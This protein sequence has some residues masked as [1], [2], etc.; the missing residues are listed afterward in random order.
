MGKQ[1][2]KKITKKK[3]KTLRQSS[4]VSNPDIT[5]GSFQEEELLHL[6]QAPENSDLLD[7]TKEFY[8]LLEAAN[9]H[10]KTVSRSKKEE[11]LEILS[12][13]LVGD[14]TCVAFAFDETHML[15]AS[16]RNNH[17]D[18]QVSVEPDFLI[19]PGSSYRDGFFIRPQ[20][21]VCIVKESKIHKFEQ[22]GEIVEF[23]YELGSD[24][25]VPTKDSL[26]F[27]P[28]KDLILKWGELG[29]NPIFSDMAYTFT[30]AK[31]PE[32]TSSFFQSICLSQKKPSNPLDFEAR[33]KIGIRS[34]LPKT[35]I[36]PF[37][38]RIDIVLQ[39]LAF[40]SHLTLP[41]NEH[42]ALGGK[43]SLKDQKVRLLQ[44][45]FVW[46]A[47]KWFG[48][49]K[50]LRDYTDAQ[51]DKFKEIVDNFI[52]VIYEKF[53]SYPDDLDMEDRLKRVKEEIRTGKI[54]PPQIFGSQIK[55]FLKDFHR[56]LKDIEKVE[57]F[58][59]DDTKRNGSLS[60]FLASKV[61]P[62]LPSPA[63]VLD[64][65]EDNVHAEM[66]VILH[67]ILN[68][69]E[70]EHIAISKLCCAHCTLVM[71]QLGI[72]SVCGSHA[73]AYPNWKLSDVFIK[74]KKLLKKILGKNLYGKYILLIK[75]MMTL[76]GEKYSKGYLA[77]LIIQS[78]AALSE[79]SLKDLNISN[80]KLW[81]EGESE[82]PDPLDEKS[83]AIQRLEDQSDLQKME[84]DYQE[85]LKKQ[86]ALIKKLNLSLTD[87]EILHK[88][89][90]L[91]ADES[92]LLEKQE[93]YQLTLKLFSLHQALVAQAR[94]VAQE[95]GRDV[96]QS[97][98]WYAMI[99]NQ[100][101]TFAEDV[102]TGDGW[103][104]LNAAGIENPVSSLN[105][106]RAALNDH[107]VR[108]YLMRSI[109][110]NI[111]AVSLGENF[112]IT[113]FDNDN[114][115]IFSTIWDLYFNLQTV[116]SNSA[117][118]RD[119]YDKFIGYISRDDVLN[120][121]LDYLIS[122]RY[123][124]QNIAAVCLKLQGKKLV[125]FHNYLGSGKLTSNAA[126]HFDLNDP[127]TVCI[128][129]HPGATQSSAHYNLLKYSP[130]PVHDQLSR[131]Q[132]EIH[133][134]AAASDIPWDITELG[135]NRLEATAYGRHIAASTNP[136]SVE[137]LDEANDTQRNR[138]DQHDT[139]SST[140]RI[141]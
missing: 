141:L 62:Y 19:M 14:E 95:F 90:K 81:S 72:T 7:F 96:V 18:V 25:L 136:T 45:T 100:Q 38:R 9:P 40:A 120:A 5:R 107:S 41:R 129:F 21:R 82:F 99:D 116:E 139:K 126:N 77:L 94:Y 58:V 59:I 67:F 2:Q 68:K 54:T 51:Q 57:S 22:P 87:Y 28:S 121:Y 15:I 55:R 103:C 106:L 10:R 101:I 13:L 140:L 137:T 84:I 46:E 74:N 92:F 34:F 85:T 75:K 70:P 98:E 105:S 113:G 47:A 93:L 132:S 122:S 138:A 109:E 12:R 123:V 43:A 134:N 4:V 33:E 128:I 66:R 131:L 26:Q 108:G 8:G 111:H 36:D 1:K 104:T 32:A 61:S 3:R 23:K 30:L 60:R 83:I 16:N 125:A 63:L 115:D 52:S 24:T 135:E 117:L 50:D 130:S 73:K 64:D 31:I 89:K 27:K 48:K 42:L 86:N 29:F 133:A 119:S 49:N 76:E 102:D 112:N 78:I 11:N 118:H 71:K 6:L 91:K 88:L 35:N 44:Q 56:Y 39:Y 65:L 17:L 80:K 124:D 37:R 114:H 110:N 127:N 53:C 69:K 79:K 20:Y 97:V